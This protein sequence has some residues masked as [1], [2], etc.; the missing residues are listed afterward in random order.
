MRESVY[1]PNAEEPWYYVNESK[2]HGFVNTTTNACLFDNLDQ[3]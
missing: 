2:I 3:T 1:V